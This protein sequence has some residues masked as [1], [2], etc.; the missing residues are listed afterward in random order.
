MPREQEKITART[1]RQMR[2]V[3]SQFQIRDNAGENG[4]RR[5]EGCIR[6]YIRNVARADRKHRPARV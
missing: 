5:I 2:T 6:R 1:G 4:E 3:S